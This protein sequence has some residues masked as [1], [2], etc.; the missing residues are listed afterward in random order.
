[1]EV[2]Q[3]LQF[4]LVTLLFSLGGC[5]TNEVFEQPTKELSLNKLQNYR[6]PERKVEIAVYKFNDQTGQRKPS[7]SLAS[8]STAVTQ[9]AASLLVQALKGAGNGKWFTVV[10]RMHLDHF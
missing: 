4:L 2:K 3:L 10:E 6:P 9:G 5:S 1:M 7:D 8:L